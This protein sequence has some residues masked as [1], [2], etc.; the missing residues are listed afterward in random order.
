MRAGQARM[1]AVEVARAARLQA[2][3]PGLPPS[4]APSGVVL[5]YSHAVPTGRFAGLSHLA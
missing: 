2:R 5:G 1:N 4:A 3:F